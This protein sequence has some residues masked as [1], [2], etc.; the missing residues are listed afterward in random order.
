MSR[1]LFL[2]ALV[3]AAPAQAQTRYFA[4]IPDLPLPSGFSEVDVAPVFEGQGRL[5]F[6]EA[7]GPGD[8]LAVRDF[9]VATLPQL[10]WSEGVESGAIV[11]QRGR[12]RLHL[13]L[14]REGESRVRLRV[15]LAVRP[16]AMDAD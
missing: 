15:Q 6:A 8:G 1:A 2:A 3:C 13:F 12:E 11:F 10:G 7:I 14:T 9:Y 5:V 4:G 16:A